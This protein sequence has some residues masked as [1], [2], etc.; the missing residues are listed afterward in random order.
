[1][2]IIDK[3]LL[4]VTDSTG[5]LTVFGLALPIFIENISIHLIGV[6]QTAL[7]SHYYDGYFVMPNNVVNQILSLL[8]T[9]SALVAT[10]LGIV[11]SINLGR[12]KH[13]R[14]GALIGT[15]FI[16]YEAFLVVFMAIAAILA[17]PL[18][19]VYG[20]SRAAYPDKYDY[21]V[22]YMRWRCLILAVLLCPGLL[23]TAL[24]CYGHTHVS[25]VA[26]TVA[27]VFN[28]IL[29]YLFLYVVCVEKEYAL[30]V[31]IGVGAFCSIV[32]SSITLGFFLHYKLPFKFVFDKSLFKS[33]FHVG[34]PA[35]VSSV[36]YSFSQMVTSI[37]CL[38]LAEIS[39]D[40][41][42][43]VTNIIY[44]VYQLGFSIGQANSILMGHVCGTGDLDKADRMHRQN[45]RLVIMC[46]VFFSLIFA[47][48]AKP[49]IRIFTDEQEILAMAEI[50]L[51]VDVFVE[52]G[53][54]MNHIGQ[55]GL[56][57]TGDTKYTTIVSSVSCWVC[58]V[59]LAYVF[60]VLF[61]WGLVGIWSAF[62]V[63]E[64]FRGIL[65]YIRWRKEGWRRSF[66]KERDDL[67]K[68][69]QAT[70]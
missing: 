53:R 43:Y 33:V 14:S 22:A 15:C 13:E 11:L 32:S 16:A 5:K 42:I 36:A 62:A 57:A 30:Y 25:L 37:I 18:L 17:E 61:D 10:G 63:D 8:V 24:R 66:L 23:G 48:F 64:L 56:N 60:G 49:L 55:F 26:N 31:F 21:S 69:E 41:K 51:W 12:G 2:K 1:S 7:S 50:I 34:S 45:L 70:A 19:N 47:L 54:G 67:E 27:N 39:Y 46:N 4:S 40:A 44:F 68:G 38:S 20:M 52:F 29:I 35:T 28:A 59:G 6:V 9:I 3:D 65:Y 58:S